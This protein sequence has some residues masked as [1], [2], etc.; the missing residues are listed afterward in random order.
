MRREI[1][2]CGSSG[3]I[4][5]LGMSACIDPGPTG[6]PPPQVL[7][8]QANGCGPVARL[9]VG[10]ALDENRVMTVAHTLRGAKVVTAG[11]AA[12]RVVYL[13]HRADVAVLST[14][15][16]PELPRITFAIPKKG[17]AV[18]LRPAV[19]ESAVL[20][21][22]ATSSGK[23][24]DIDI[25]NVAA[26]NI[27]EPIDQATYK[28][29]GF[30]ARISA[31]KIAVGDSGSPVVDSTGAVVGMVFANDEA[32]ERTLFA[33][34]GSELDAVSRAAGNFAVSTGECDD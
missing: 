29:A 11:G 34:S 12:A 19:L 7:V 16:R 31:G 15:A 18:L 13:D 4:L 20:E 22:E 26:I 24:T 30:V 1:K 28:R 33:V 14:A 3:V 5:A 2:I 27:D 21:S 10:F 23:R 32:T 25:S 17:P 6:R 8:V 9:A